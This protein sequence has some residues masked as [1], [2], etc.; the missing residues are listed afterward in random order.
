MPEQQTTQTSQIIYNSLSTSPR[1][2][3]FEQRRAQGAGDQVRG[4]RQPVQGV[5]QLVQGAAQLRQ[6]AGHQAKNVK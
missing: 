3:R 1:L 2:K 4:A 6:Q 5:P